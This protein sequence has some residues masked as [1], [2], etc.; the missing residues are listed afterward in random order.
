MNEQV[1][2]SLELSHLL[3]LF[4]QP[5]DFVNLMFFVCLLSL[6]LYRSVLY[7]SQVVLNFPWI[8]RAS[9]S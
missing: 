3:V 7:F 5:L 8:L 4:E 9:T 1:N 6:Q 2:L